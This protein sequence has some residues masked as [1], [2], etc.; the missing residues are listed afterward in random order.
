MKNRIL[1]ISLAVILAFSA[2]ITGCTPP[3]N[4]DGNGP[5]PQDGCVDFEDL[6]LGAEYHVGDT[7]N[8]SGVVI[9]VEQ[10][11]GTSGYAEVGNQGLAGGSGQEIGWINNVNLRFDFL[12]PCEVL[13]ILFG[14]YGGGLYI[15]I[16]G[17]PAT[18]TDFS[19]VI[20]PI[21]GVHF[22]V[23][24]YG[25]GKGRLKLTGTINRDSL[26]IG[27]QEL[28][29]DHICQE[30]PQEQPTTLCIDFEDLPLGGEYHVGDS[31]VD[32]GVVIAVEHFQWGNGQ[33][34]DGG[35]AKVENEGLAGS[36]GQEMAVNN[37]NLRFDFGDSSYTGLSLRYGEYGGNINIEINGDLRN[38][39]DFSD[40]MSPVGGVHVS[41]GNL[42]N[43]MGA[44]VLSGTINSLAIGGQELWID[45]IC[46]VYPV[47][48]TGKPDLV[49]VPALPDMAF[50]YCD[51]DEEGLYVH[52]K[53]EGT[54]TAPSFTTE[55]EFK[56]TQP[57]ANSETVSIE[58]STL[59]AGDTRR[60]GPFPIPSLCWDPDCDFT[61]TID[62]EQKISELSEINN[63]V[64]GRCLG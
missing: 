39:A 43:G 45:H 17:Q 55:V 49:P 42:G 10:F 15:E 8:P 28:A 51:R 6:P 34:T 59:P 16:N 7:I 13:Y 26:V 36:S 1:F 2:S 23:E 52:V 63:S 27:G 47:G 19:D 12:G 48:E 22:R 5:E 20:E 58:T 35:Y 30:S 24:H 9:T 31:F 4:G 37:V 64:D 41:T 14:A 46:R 11:Q 62:P 54:A 50:P 33:W 29:I 60:V 57:E 25:D 32:S 56:W 3:S 21:G 61:V 53:N 18:V 44:L 38:V 40:V